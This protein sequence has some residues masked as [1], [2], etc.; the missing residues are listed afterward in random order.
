M[1]SENFRE[2]RKL[3]EQ[4]SHMSSRQAGILYKLDELLMDEMCAGYET[5][6]TSEPDEEEA[7]SPT[8]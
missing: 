4:L 6:A 3:V 1:L 7:S 8:T 5:T 2:V